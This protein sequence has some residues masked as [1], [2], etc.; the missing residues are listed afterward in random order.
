[1]G[2]GWGGRELGA[3]T[4]RCIVLPSHRLPGP[5]GLPLCSK[6]LQHPRGLPE[7]LG[8][9]SPPNWMPWNL[10][11]DSL[12]WE[13]KNWELSKLGRVRVPGERA[14]LYPSMG[15]HRRCHG[16]QVG[17]ASQGVRV[18]VVTLGGVSM[19]LPRIAR[20]YVDPAASW[21]VA[22]LKLT[23]TALPV[24]GE[25]SMCCGRAWPALELP[26]GPLAAW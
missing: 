6:M 24:A 17:D 14:V 5:A 21:G 12:C 8:C 11:E 19:R 25:L 1:M 22:L 16:P 9:S 7:A 2:H 13:K 4:G 20:G 26:Q 15:L 3:Q 10:S 18:T 23:S